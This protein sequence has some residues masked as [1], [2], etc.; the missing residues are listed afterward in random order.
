LRQLLRKSVLAWVVFA[1][2]P[3][4]ASA[5]SQTRIVFVD[6]QRVID[7]SPQLIEGKKRV[8]AELLATEQKLRSDE[9]KLNALKAK[10]QAEA[11]VLTRAQLD[12]LVRTIEASERAL[13]RGRDEFNQRLN[14]RT[15]EVVRELTRKLSDTIAEV[16]KA[17]GADAVISL[18]STVYSNPRLDIT[19]AVLV[20]LRGGK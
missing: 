20:K 10:R 12:D 9:A 18:N 17:Q 6:M 5:Q 19:E 13:K 11:A 8:A 2:L 14:T 16:A 1:L 7:S 3:L 15:N 4:T